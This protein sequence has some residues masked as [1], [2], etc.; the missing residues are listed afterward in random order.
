MLVLKF[1]ITLRGVSI[2]FRAKLGINFDFYNI[3]KPL[4]YVFYIQLYS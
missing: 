1:K 4:M 2:N 3:S